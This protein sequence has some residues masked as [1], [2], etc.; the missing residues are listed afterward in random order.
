MG[1]R[2]TCVRPKPDK[3]KPIT[4]LGNPTGEVWFSEMDAGYQVNISPNSWI[5]EFL[6]IF[7][8]TF[9]SVFFLVH[10]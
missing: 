8:D 10:L 5:V 2:S 1:R 9:Y 3:T 7:I 4:Y 6:N